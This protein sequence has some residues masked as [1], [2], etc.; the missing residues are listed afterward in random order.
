[1]F[2]GG[3]SPFGVV[4]RFGMCYTFPGALGKEVLRMGPWEIFQTVIVFGPVIVILAF[5]AAKRSRY[6]NRKGA[7]AFF[8][9]NDCLVLN[10]GIP[11]PVPLG[12]I[13]HVELNYNSWELDHLLSYGLW[14]K[15]VRRSG[16]SKRVFYKGYKTAALATPF[17]MEAALTE[18]GIRCVMKD[19]NKHR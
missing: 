16:Q 9:E 14:V 10:T 2:P 19:D 7:G 18:R 1:M 15:V 17:D 12:E 5:F 3:F 4:S 11:Y 6:K 13:D 8:F